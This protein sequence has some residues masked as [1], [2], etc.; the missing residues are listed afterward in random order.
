MLW[1]VINLFIILIFIALFVIFRK[2]NKRWSKI[3]DYLG[4]VNN[5]VNSIRYGNLSTKMG[6]IEHPNYK[7]LTDSINRM[8]E[9][10]NDRE[11]MIIEYQNELTNQNKF[12]ESVINSLSD[13]ILIIDENYNILRVTPKIADWFKEDGNKIINKNLLDFI[14]SEKN[15]KPEKFNQDEIFIKSNSESSFEATTMKLGLDDKKKRFVVI[16]KDITNQKEIESLREDFVATLTHDLKVPIVAESNILEFLITGKFGEVNEKQLEA[17]SNMKSCNNELLDLVQIL[18]ETYKIKEAGIVL[19]KENI[20]LIQFI[21]SAIE[22][23]QPIAQKSDIKLFFQYEHEIK[24]SADIMQLKRVIKNLIQNALSHSESN[25]DIN[26]RLGQYE[27]WATISII[28]YGKGISPENIDKIFNKYYST[29]KKFRKIGTGL[30]LYLSQQ[31]IKSHGGEIT[32]TSQE[33]VSTE[34]C[35]KLPMQ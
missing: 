27:N 24:V 10:L 25:N 18:L 22:E 33:N 12:L 32:V 30:G 13:G 11:K 7:N 15:A 6:K 17:I 14:Q 29:V 3:N 4:M 35:I 1:Y 16:I 20:D 21:G 34:F 8:V 5:T 26:I 2:S 23:M 28:D 31:I 19:F 9:T